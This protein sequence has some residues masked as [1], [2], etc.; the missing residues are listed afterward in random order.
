M[1]V[2]K[3]LQKCCKTVALILEKVVYIIIMKLENNKN[4]KNNTKRLIAKV[5]Q[6]CGASSQKNSY[7]N[8]ISN[9]A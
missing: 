3:V 4:T 2:A 5:L 8:T 6:K 7:I 1:G 9:V